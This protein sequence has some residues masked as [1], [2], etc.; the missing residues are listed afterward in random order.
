MKIKR[1]DLLI[2]WA[3]GSTSNISDYLPSGLSADLE[4]FLDYWEEHYGE[5]ESEEVEE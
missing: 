4:G 2:T 5:E 1:Y 3:D